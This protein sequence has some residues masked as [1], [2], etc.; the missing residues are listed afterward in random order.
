MTAYLYIQF[1]H[2]H[3]Q[4]IYIY[5]YTYTNYTYTCTYIHTHTHTYIPGKQ[6]FV[7]L[8]RQ[9]IN[10][11]DVWSFSKRAY[12]WYLL[13]PASCPKFDTIFGTVLS[14]IFSLFSYGTPCVEKSTGC[15]KFGEELKS[16]ERFWQ[17]MVPNKIR[18]FRCRKWDS[19]QIFGHLPL[20]YI[21]ND[22]L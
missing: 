2:I 14:I 15:P 20:F 7:F 5:M 22:F 8:R 21:V 4:Y 6:K 17:P 12:L 3:I 1:I 10:G 11:I 19:H 16:E 9:T 18:F 13:L